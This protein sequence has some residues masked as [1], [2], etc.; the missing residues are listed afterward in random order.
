MFWNRAIVIGSF[1]IKL[2][3]WYLSELRQKHLYR[4]THRHHAKYS[5]IAAASTESW[6][7]ISP[8]SGEKSPHTCQQ[9]ESSNWKQFNQDDQVS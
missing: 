3:V 6:S 2:I 9:D 8:Q 4:V 1:A 7:S 5:S